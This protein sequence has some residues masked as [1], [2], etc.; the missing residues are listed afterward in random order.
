MEKRNQRFKP[1]IA[2]MASCTYIFNL[3]IPIRSEQYRNN[4]CKNRME[5][6]K[7]KK[8]KTWFSYQTHFT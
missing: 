8:K 4:M 6:G 2:T 1:L 3:Q 5:E 7:K